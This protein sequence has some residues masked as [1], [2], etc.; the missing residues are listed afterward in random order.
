MCVWGAG[1]HLW[2]QCGELSWASSSSDVSSGDS[3]RVKIGTK[4]E[5]KLGELKSGRL[6]GHSVWRASARAFSNKNCY[7]LLS[8]YHV[9]GTVLTALPGLSHLSSKQLYE[10]GIIIIPLLHMRKLKLIGLPRD[11]KLVKGSLS[12][13]QFRKITLGTHL[14]VQSR[15]LICGISVWKYHTRDPV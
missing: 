1:V 12:G 13:A 3:D 11:T 6:Y 2:A 7:H 5:P 8:L 14:G 4:Q 10:G 15:E 9:L